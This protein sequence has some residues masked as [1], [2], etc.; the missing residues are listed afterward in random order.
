M[1][2]ACTMVIV[3]SLF[4]PS[5]IFSQKESTERDS[6]VIKR[7][8][9]NLE[10]LADDAL[11]GRNASSMGEKIA[12]RFIKTELEKNN[13]KPFGD[14]ETYFQNFNVKVRCLSEEP[15]VPLIDKSGNVL[16]YLTPGPDFIV[17][18][19]KIFDSLFMKKN[20]EI[21]FAGYG[22]TAD[23]YGYDDY[24]N[25]DVKGK[26]VMLLAGEPVSDDSNF[27][28]GK[29]PHSIFIRCQ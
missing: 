12:A 20:A 26:I 18:D 11:E 21:V 7:L 28:K 29:D 25:I 4:I 19:S 13:I 10:F 23:E 5:L 8:K 17:D 16:E 6:E 14:N 1:K 27:F 15:K 3:L 22:I 2:K 24:K 9:A